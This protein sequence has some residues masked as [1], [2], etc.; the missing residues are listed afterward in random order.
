M[1]YSRKAEYN[2]RSAEKKRGQGHVEDHETSTSLSHLCVH[3]LMQI[4]WDATPPKRYMLM[5]NNTDVYSLLH[6]SVERTCRLDAL[7][8]ANTVP[9]TA[10]YLAYQSWAPKGDSKV[11]KDEFASLLSS[12]L[13]GA[14]QGS[15][16]V[17]AMAMGEEE[18]EEDDL[19]F[20]QQLGFTAAEI[21]MEKE[22]RR[23]LSRDDLSRLP[24]NLLPYTAPSQPGLQQ[25]EGCPVQTITT[26][27][28]PFQEDPRDERFARKLAK[29]AAIRNNTNFNFNYNDARWRALHGGTVHKRAAGRTS[30]AEVWWSRWLGE[31]AVDAS[32]LATDFIPK[33]P[34]EEKIAQ[35][36]LQGGLA[37]LKEQTDVPLTV[38]DL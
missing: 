30:G 24:Y 5:G 7:P 2:L 22:K 18:D 13:V 23:P 34:T 15:I 12:S 29:W 32:T 21:A 17:G 25:T 37:P 6:A 4:S 27:E 19:E 10:K 8:G 33:P 28:E 31:K 20:A 3:A 26:K 9:V 16:G 35:A 38:L 11:G 1:V 14:N 36:S